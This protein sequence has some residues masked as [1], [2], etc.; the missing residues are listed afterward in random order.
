M[1]WRVRRLL[2]LDRKQPD[3][4]GT[5]VADVEW[6]RSE[7]LRVDRLGPG[8]DD[9]SDPEKIRDDPWRP[10]RTLGPIKRR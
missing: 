10:K 5:Y 9:V 8:Q 3:S 7:E 4:R 1:N 2:G 6:K